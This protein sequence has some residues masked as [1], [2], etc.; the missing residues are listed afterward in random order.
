MRVLITFGRL[1][2]MQSRSSL[3]ECFFALVKAG[4][5]EKRV[6]L[7]EYESI[8]YTEIYQLAEGQSLTGLIAVG[9]EHVEDVKLPQE[10]TLNFV[11]AVLQIEHRNT[12]MNLFIAKLVEKMN[13]AGIYALL[14]KG[15]GIAQCYERPLWR[16]SGDVDLLLDEENYHNAVRFLT[17]LASTI[18]EEHKHI[19]HQAYTINSWEV[20][21]HGTLRSELGHRID[22]V[23][24]VV[25]R[26]TFVNQ[27]TRSW[28]CGGTDVLLPDPDNDIIFVFTHI[29]QHFF[30]E[31]IGLR[32]I[33]DWC[34]L[35]WTYRE[36]IDSNL[37]E[38]RLEAMNVMKEWKSFAALAVYDLDM[39]KEAMPFFSSLPEWKRN[40][41][42]LK[43]VILETGNFGYNRDTS[44]HE[45]Y[46]LMVCK[47]ITFF[48]MTSLALRRAM[49]FPMCSMR[50]WLKLVMNR[51]KSVF[52]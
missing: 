41:Y 18:R 23:I 49:L 44:Y 46:S 43:H 27:K 30:L 5:W 37:L 25:Q 13:D 1:P 17:P 52:V 32:Q 26:D 22:N 50:V 7:S 38:C 29:L 14:V 42:Q 36:E 51:M 6:R 31:G 40:A 33:C 21:L 16:A 15:Q 28:K 45:K 48:D 12:S 24:D 39:P 20:E 2:A 8:D 10:A 3:H 34:R 11:G 35:L 4:L 9:I 19:L 47:M